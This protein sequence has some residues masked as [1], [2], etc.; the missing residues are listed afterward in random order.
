MRQL[1]LVSQRRG[2]PWDW[3]K[4]LLEQEL[5]DQH[6]DFMDGLVEEGFVV[7]GGPL[8][9][10]DVL[11]VVHS[12]TE[13]AVPARFA[14]D[15][16]IKNGMLTITSIRPWTILLEG[17]LGTARRPAPEPPAHS[18]HSPSLDIHR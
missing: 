10:R 14:P 17:R 8:N 18:P 16:W 4:G 1:F 7:L 12:W 3:S 13:A 2:G 5:F 6:G 11:L 9:E 15:P